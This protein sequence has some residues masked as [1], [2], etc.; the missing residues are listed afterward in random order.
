LNQPSLE[1]KYYS[2]N[3]SKAND[4]V[5]WDS[6]GPWLISN[7]SHGYYQFNVPEL[8]VQSPANSM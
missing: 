2:I 7:K 4:Q 1:S 8:V 6:A 3:I 5:A